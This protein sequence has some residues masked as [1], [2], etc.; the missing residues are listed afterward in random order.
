MT[1]R[2][3]APF[4]AALA[5]ILLHLPALRNDFVFDDRGVLLQ[6]PLLADLR[7]APRLLSAPYWNAPGLTGGLYRP[8]TSL[9]FALDRALAQGFRPSWFHATNV[10]LHAV[11]TGLLVLLALRMA[12]R[13]QAALL[14]GVLFAVHPVHV[15]AV[16]GIVGRAELLAAA[17]TLGA[18]LC[19]GEARR[20][21][22]R[23]GTLAA[24]G[25]IGCGFFALLAKESAF[26][27]PAIAW[28]YDRAFPASRPLRG[29]TLVVS[30]IAAV[31][32]ALGLRA[33][34][35]GGL[36]SAPIP[37]VDNPAAS[38]G[39]FLGRVAALAV[40][41]RIARLLVW[42][43]PLS[44]DY[45]YAQIPLPSGPLDP[46]VLFGAAIALG[47]VAAGILALRRRPAL[48]FSLL[49]IPASL[50]LTCNLV[51]FIGTLLGERLLYLPSAGVCLAAVVLAAEATPGRFPRG[52]LV[53]AGVVAIAGCAIAFGAWRTFT[54]LADWRDDFSLYASAARVSPRSTRIRYNLGNAW[55]RR[56]GFREAEAE[57]RDALAIYPDF[58]DARGNL[59]LALLQQGRAQEALEP[60]EEA[61]RRQPRNPEVRVNLG[62]ARRLLGDGAGA[63][64]EFEAAIALS[65]NAASAWNDLGSLLLAQGEADEAIRCLERAAQAE[66]AYALY[67]VNLADAYNAA[68]R[69]DEARA[70]FE[71]AFR[72]DPGAP[73]SIRGRGELLLGRGDAAEAEKAFRA[74][75]GGTPPSP[76][77]ANFL[78]YLLA[79]RGDR[80]GA[81]AAYEKA[82]AL[83]PTLWDAHRSLGLIYAAQTADRTRAIEH[84]RASLRLEPGQ[85]G[86]ADLRARLETLESAERGAA[87][88]G[89]R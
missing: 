48:G 63:R 42:P 17:G 70:Q 40:V 3:A 27:L 36:G 68:G 14:A 15:E 13:W 32:L 45:S 53:R 52:R 41:P 43:H 50:L 5:A 78:G 86:A 29:R 26:A 2:R 1:G 37:F 84:L 12:L 64:R 23:P 51:V 4:L 18:L 81:L 46:R 6:N 34:A 33:H 79:R 89:G 87:P 9:T 75:A 76:R 77:A 16:A 66:P 59:G 71:A 44:A 31:A 35:L 62:S 57:Y 58:A 38:A 21:D 60:L 61:A 22:G 20:R 24:A 83:D 28:L 69:Q 8:A 72:I 25:A 55:L 65:G 10:L 74:A 19:L 30:G 54:R 73:E 67:R 49:L 11:V 82:V 39:P 56:G 80:A 47:V 88:G 7:S 85:D